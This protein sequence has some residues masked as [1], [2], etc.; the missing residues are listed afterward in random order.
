MRKIIYSLAA[1]SMIFAGCTKEVVT[2]ELTDN[3]NAIGFDISTSKTRATIADIT[4]LQDATSGIGIYATKNNGE[5]VQTMYIDN[6]AYIYDGAKWAWATEQLWPTT[7]SDYP[8]NFYAYWPA[9]KDY[10]YDDLDETLVRGYSANSVGSDYDYLAANYLGVTTR[11]ASSNLRLDFK[12]IL[13]QIKFQVVVGAGMSVEI[14]S[15]DIHNI[16]NSRLFNFGT[17]EWMAEPISRSL[18]VNYKDDTNSKATWEVGDGIS[19]FA[20][21]A[22]AMDGNRMLIPQNNSSHAWNKTAANLGTGAYVEVVY[23]MWNTATGEDVV[24]YYAAIDHPTMRAQYEGYTKPS[25]GQY[26]NTELYVKVG[27]PLD[28]NWKMEKSYTYTIYLGTPNA[29]GG[30]LVDDTFV[31]EWGIDS[32]YSVVHPDTE[33]PINVGDPI[34]DLTQPIDFIVD[35]N[36]WQEYE[37]NATQTVVDGGYA[38]ILYLDAENRLAIG[39]YGVDPVT[40]N[41][42]V[43]TKYG[44]VVG[45][46]G[47]GLR[48]TGWI[49]SDVKFNPTSTTYST[50]A[51]I[52]YH[53]GSVDHYGV[54][55]KSG[56]G[57]ICKLVGL[58][59]TEAQKKSIAELDAYDSGWRLPTV[60]ENISFVGGAP[61]ASWQ[62]WKVSDYKDWEDPEYCDPVLTYTNTAP[63]GTNKK[64][65]YFYSAL[66]VPT[67]GYGSA[68]SPATGRFPVVT[69]NYNKDAYSQILPVAGGTYSTTGEASYSPGYGV[70]Y[71]AN[72]S[73]S[74]FRNGLFLRITS[75]SVNPV[76]FTLDDNRAAAIRCV[77]P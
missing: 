68:A 49:A 31:G 30:Y 56:R 22:T 50:Y 8:M 34:V 19:K 17:L 54:H 32:G 3:P 41:N 57:D 11:P 33:E 27:Y 43:F 39:K 26:G 6:E 59:S 38:D 74:E 20:I 9:A 5:G 47:S 62:T 60:Y 63:D 66:G 52:P 40:V 65:Q 51:S 45:F 35:V 36:P 4:K 7:G 16:A 28:T 77:R 12:H 42:M 10:T 24:G 75:A 70:D 23:R 1:A 18:D 64:W 48:E 37:V 21:P 29:T 2:S 46:T 25:H 55:V 13:S 15:M 72:N 71:W 76:V 14:I 67:G 69:D 61:G 44:G 58:T 73:P 53:V